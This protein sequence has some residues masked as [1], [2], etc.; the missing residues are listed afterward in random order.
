MT[1][2]LLLAL[3]VPGAAALLV[4][5]WRLGEALLDVARRATA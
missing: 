3:V 2:G 1:S 4:V 5:C